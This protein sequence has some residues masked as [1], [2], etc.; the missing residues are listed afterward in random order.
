MKPCTFLRAKKRRFGFEVGF[1]QTAAG[2]GGS[3][4]RRQRFLHGTKAVQGGWEFGSRFVMPF[5]PGP[6]AAH[7]LTVAFRPAAG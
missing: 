3:P 7:N 2:V 5:I 6:G 1:E 4:R